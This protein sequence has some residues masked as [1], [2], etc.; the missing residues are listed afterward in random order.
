MSWRCIILTELGIHGGTLSFSI[1]YPSITQQVG[2]NTDTSFIREMGTSIHLQASL[3][4]IIAF[5]AK[6]AIVYEAIHVVCYLIKTI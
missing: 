1:A 2:D 5:R 3:S 4:S 6:I